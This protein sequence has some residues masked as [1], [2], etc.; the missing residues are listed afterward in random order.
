MKYFFLQILISL[1]LLAPSWASA[2]VLVVQSLSIKPYNDALNGFR[3]VCNGRLNRIAGPGLSEPEILK[4]VRRSRPE[5]ILA[6]GM[7]ALD[8]L[9]SIKDVPIIYVMVL[10][11]RN[12]VPEGGNITGISMKIAPEKQ[13]AVLRELLPNVRRIGVFFDPDK[14]GY[15]VGRASNAASLMGIEL[16]T[17]KVKSSKEAVAAIDAIKGKVDA[18]WLLPDTTVVNQGTIDLLLLSSLENSIPVITFSDKYA[19]K[20]ALLSLEVDPVDAGKQAGE[21]A[22]RLLGGTD[23]RKIANEDARS[24]IITVNLLVA[25]KLGIHISASAINHARIIR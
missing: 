13:F 18:L 4:K 7:D 23:I 25:K 5:L 22:N 15:Y 12:L 21:M 9:K 1:F 11:P 24:A 6:I 20:G 8:K 17:K 10:S 16:L 2:E 3:A 14:S 19:E